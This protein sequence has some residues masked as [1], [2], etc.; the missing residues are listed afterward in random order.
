MHDYLPQAEQADGTGEGGSVAELPDST[1]E[2]QPVSGSTIL[3]L[4]VLFVVLVVA[5][6]LAGSGSGSVEEEDD[7]QEEREE[8]GVLA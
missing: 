6:E 8:V 5:V 4:T 3:V 2:D 7:D 1:D